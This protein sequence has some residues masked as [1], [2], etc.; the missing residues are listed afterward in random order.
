MI[1]ALLEGV[2]PVIYG[3]GYWLDQP[4]APYWV[5]AQLH[6]GTAMF[7]FVAATFM[8]RQHRWWSMGYAVI[9]GVWLLGDA[10]AVTTQYYPPLGIR[11]I[12]G[13]AG[14]IGMLYQAAKVRQ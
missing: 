1:K 13:L 2:L 6:A 5:L 4:L 8:A 9:I 11:H 7:A 3:A 10:F 12:L 14:L